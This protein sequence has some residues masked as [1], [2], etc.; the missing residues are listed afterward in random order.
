MWHIVRIY[1]YY[2]YYYQPA[3]IVILQSMIIYG[4][5]GVE[6]QTCGFEIEYS[7]L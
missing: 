4:G 2:G 6:K 1:Y 7:F 5:C 3:I